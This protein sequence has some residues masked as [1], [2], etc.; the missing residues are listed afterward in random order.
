M[1]KYL[2]RLKKNAYKC[3]VL[4]L[5]KCIPCN[6]AFVE[7]KTAVITG[8]YSACPMAIFFNVDN[9]SHLGKTFDMKLNQKCSDGPK[10]INP[11]PAMR[12]VLVKS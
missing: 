8:P 6:R 7:K 12:N 3:D 10:T 11:Y 5:K 2:T 9:K 1:R 4:S